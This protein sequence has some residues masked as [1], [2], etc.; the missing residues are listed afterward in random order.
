MQRVAV[1]AFFKLAARVI[2]GLAQNLHVSKRQF[3]PRSSQLFELG[4]DL[5]AGLRRRLCEAIL[6]LRVIFP[7]IAFDCARLGCLCALV[8]AKNSRCG[9]DDWR[10]GLVLLRG[11]QILDGANDRLARDD[12]SEDDVLAV[13]VGYSCE[14]P[15]SKARLL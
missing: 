9:N 3:D 4:G 12:L 7:D 10:D 15:V 11:R 1:V 2:P 5:E 8:W 13:E 6:I 14:D